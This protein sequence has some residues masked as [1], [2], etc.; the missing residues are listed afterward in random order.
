MDITDLVS[1]LTSWLNWFGADFC[2]GSVYPSSLAVKLDK[3]LSSRF[4]ASQAPYLLIGLLYIRQRDP[5]SR[6]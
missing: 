1:A 5:E 2:I 4:F 6:Q 3:A